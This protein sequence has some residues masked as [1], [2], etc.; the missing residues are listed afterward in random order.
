MLVEVVWDDSQIVFLISYTD[1]GKTH[2]RE[3]LSLQSKHSQ[4]GHHFS[5][6]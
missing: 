3:R 6:K 1:F 2:L 4:P 5:L